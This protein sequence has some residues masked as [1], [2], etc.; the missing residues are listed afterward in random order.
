MGNAQIVPHRILTWNGGL[1]FFKHDLL[2]YII[3]NF[4]SIKC[5]I[6]FGPKTMTLKYLCNRKE[7]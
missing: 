3:P 6:D 1:T 4:L 2:N 5:D 7:N